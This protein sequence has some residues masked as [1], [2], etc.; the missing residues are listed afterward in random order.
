LNEGLNPVA[1]RGLNAAGEVDLP[2]ERGQ[3]L[4]CLQS[5]IVFND[6]A[7]VA[8]EFVGEILE[9]V[10]ELLEAASGLGGDA[11]SNH[12]AVMASRCLH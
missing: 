1:H 9:G 12:G 11:A 6:R 8:D 4:Y 3:Q 2:I 10:T 5:S 7:S